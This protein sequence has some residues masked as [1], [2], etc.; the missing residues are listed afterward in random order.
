[1]S[2]TE[3]NLTHFDASGN[4][5]MVDVS[6]KAVTFREAVAH[7]IITMNAEAFAAVES[8]SLIHIYHLGRAVDGQQG[9]AVNLEKAVAVG[10]EFD[11][12]LLRLS[13]V[14][15]FARGSFIQ[16]GGG[17]VLVEDAGLLLP[18]VEIPVSYTHLD[19]YKRQP[20][21]SSRR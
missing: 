12:A 15:V 8:L 19:V 17:F 6:E 11:L 14:D 9:V 20:S 3:T 1:M 2:T 13:A 21:T 5:V 7:G 16:Q 10:D 18:D 4:A